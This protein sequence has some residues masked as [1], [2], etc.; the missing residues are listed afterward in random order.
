MLVALLLLTGCVSM[1]LSAREAAVGTIGKDVILAA[2][3]ALVVDTA[4]LVTAADAFCTA[5]DDAGLAAV[6]DAWWAARTPWKQASVFK[7]GPYVDEPWRYGPL[8]DD[9]PTN[10]ARLTELLTSDEVLDSTLPEDL[11][12]TTRG[13]PAVEWLL[14]VEGEG[15]LLAFTDDASGRRCSLLEL[16]AVDLD[17]NAKGIAAAWSPTGG[18]YLAT[19]ALPDRDSGGFSDHAAVLTELVNRGVFTVEDLRLERLGKPSG[20]TTGGDPHPEDVE[21]PWSARSLQDVKDGLDGVQHVWNGTRDGTPG[22]GLRSLL[23]TTQ[24][25]LAPA[26]DTAISEAAAALNA[27]PEPLAAAVTDDPDTINAAMDAL[28]ALQVLL[29]ADLTSALG[30]TVLFNDNDGD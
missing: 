28:L 16:L 3:D 17:N 23:T 22:S 21:S 19:L 12:S 4:V 29:Q 6:R 9:W 15:T 10:D 11:G 7:F 13:F 2:Y 24:A 25:D 1:P 26:I 27:V 20:L 5:P 18:D 30:V 8:L 14:W